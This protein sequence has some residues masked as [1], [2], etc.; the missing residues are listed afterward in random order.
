MSVQF[1]VCELCK[2]TYVG[3]GHNGMPLIDGRVCN[4]CNGFVIMARLQLL[5]EV[6]RDALKRRI[7]LIQKRSGEEE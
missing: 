7:P 5:S 1:K 3:Y 4:N 2:G 6:E